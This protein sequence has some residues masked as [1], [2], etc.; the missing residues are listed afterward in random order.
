M[1]LYF[2]QLPLLDH[3]KLR[4]NEELQLAHL[5]L[6]CLG[7]S[8]VH[9]DP[10]KPAQILPPQ[11][12]IPWC[13]VSKKLGLPPIIVHST[14]SLCN[15]KKL[16]P[17][18]PMILDNLKLLYSLDS[19]RDLETFFLIPL[20]VELN[21]VPAVVAIMSIQ[22]SLE[23]KE[24]NP[25]LSQHLDIIK[26]SL[27]KMKYVLKLMSPGCRPEVFYYQHRPLLSGWEDNP[28]MP[29]GLLY[30]GVSDIPRK[31]SGGSAAQ[32]S[33]LQALDA[34]LG[35]KHSG[36]EGAFLVRMREYMPPNQA[37]LIKHIEQGPSIREACIRA[38]PLIKEKYN[39]CLEALEHFRTEHLILVSRY[40]TTPSNRNRGDADHLADQGTGGTALAI[41][42][43]RVRKDISEMLLH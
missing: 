28:S 31:Y 42:L 35:V 33:S 25:N 41:F 43:K 11:I 3:E 19:S 5:L 26:E 17:C 10:S 9:E 21:S 4:S 32:S 20:L 40:I 16:D 15:W 8:Y 14:V 1:K 6:S 29:N 18:G 23:T 38:D 2:R 27:D 7:Q 36:R 24:E 22:K 30:Q 13:G 37:G 39:V 12:A 34:G